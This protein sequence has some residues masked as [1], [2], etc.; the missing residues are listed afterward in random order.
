M[1]EELVAK[2]KE[3]NINVEDFSDE[4]ELEKAISDKERSKDDDLDK[5]NDV[6]VLKKELKKYKEEAKKAFDARDSAKSERR[7]LQEKV[8]ELE[9]KIENSVDPEKISLLEKELKDLKEFKKNYDTKAEEEELK[10]KSEVEKMKIRFDK[11]F[12]QLKK[13]MEDSI[14]TTK[15]QVE[16]KEKELKKKDM[17]VEG[18]RKHRLRSEIMEAATKSKAY[19]PAQVARL[20]IDEFTYDPDLDQFFFYVRDTKG[21]ITDELEVAKRVEKFLSDPDNENL[22]LSES[23]GGTGHQQ[24]ESFSKTEKH[25]AG[26][27][28]NKYDPKDPDLQEK[29]SYRGLTVEDY[30]ETLK[31]K[32][33]KFQK[34]RE[35]K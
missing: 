18:L 28:D 35:K 2:A 4:K 20:L 32:D 30:I 31:L 29:A 16:E 24:N 9:K 5:I 23:K 13:D 14:S 22:V 11:E 21:K 8:S 6:E 12:E 3:L 34:I 33:S 26:G 15:K 19:N 7:K 25:K 27:S 10:N 1:K 17:E